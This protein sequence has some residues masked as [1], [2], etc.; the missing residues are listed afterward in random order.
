MTRCKKCN[1]ELASDHRGKKCDN[2]K[3]KALEYAKTIFLYGSLIGGASAAL[4][5]SYKK[6]RPH[7]LMMKN[8]TTK[9]M[10]RCSTDVTAAR[11]KSR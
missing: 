4:L 2:C 10:N 3:N 7:P 11:T 1:K 9:L 5:L 6:M 8:G